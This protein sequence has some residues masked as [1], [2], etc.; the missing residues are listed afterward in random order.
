MTL[1]KEIELLYRRL[2]SFFMKRLSKNSD[3][4][5]DWEAEFIAGSKLEGN[6]RENF[7]DSLVL[8]QKTYKKQN[9]KTY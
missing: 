3:I 1:S 7:F 5:E 8:A 2:K 4:Y 9:F 6:S